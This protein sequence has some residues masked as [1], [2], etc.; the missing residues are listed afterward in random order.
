MAARSD[1]IAA[2]L[3]L[4]RRLTACRRM[5]KVE[6]LELVGRR[7]G[8][9]EVAIGPAVGCFQRRVQLGLALL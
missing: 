5:I 8:Y 7:R 2:A 1:R 9:G 3:A 6:R 4:Q